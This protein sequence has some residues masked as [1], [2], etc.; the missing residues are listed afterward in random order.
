MHKESTIAKIIMVIFL[1]PHCND[2]KDS[3]LVVR[4][5][6][7]AIG[8][9]YWTRIPELITGLTYFGFII[10]IIVVAL[11]DIQLIGPCSTVY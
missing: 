11:N 2:R 9:D 10:L 8:L 1:S 7:G 5:N 6:F 4:P 3:Q